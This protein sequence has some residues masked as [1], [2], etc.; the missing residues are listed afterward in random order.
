MGK[1]F[2]LRAWRCLLS[3]QNTLKREEEEAEGGGK[4]D[5]QMRM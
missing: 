4:T 1:S 2:L 5:I 3:V